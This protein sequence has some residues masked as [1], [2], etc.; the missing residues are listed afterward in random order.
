MVM[1][2]I[3]LSEDT[4]R[5]DVLLWIGSRWLRIRTGGVCGYGLDRSG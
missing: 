4:D 3:E 5:W 2:T 1:E